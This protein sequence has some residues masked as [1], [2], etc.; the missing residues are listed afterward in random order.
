MCWHYSGLNE[1]SIAELT[2]LTTFTSDP[3]FNP[4]DSGRFS[5]E[6][7]RRLLGVFLQSDSNPF[8][9]NYGW[10]RSTVQ[11]RLPK[12]KMN[13]T[14]EM[15]PSIGTVKIDVHHRFLTDIIKSA[16]EDPVV[17]NF[18]MMPFEEYWKK[19][20]K[21]TVKVYSEVYSSPDVLQAYR[22]VHSLP[23]EP[24]DD[25]EHVVASLMLWS[26]AT[27]L[28]NFGDASLWPIYLYFGNQSKYIRGRPTASAC[29]HVVYI[30]TVWS[31]SN[32]LCSQCTNCS[33]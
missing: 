23:R 4:S 26:D 9:A 13:F 18:H 5:H 25:L 17:S 2:R 22:E 16:F 11:V 32:Y 10:Y 7:E 28:A 3:L 31:H 21:H 33:T 15:D 8:H 30:P 27:Q 14:S 19:S 29:H 1:K 24:G 12:E 20:D 6:R